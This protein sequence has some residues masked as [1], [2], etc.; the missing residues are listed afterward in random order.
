[1]SDARMAHRQENVHS[2]ADFLYH[3]QRLTHSA[4]PA[5]WL[6]LNIGEAMAVSLVLLFIAVFQDT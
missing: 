6:R 2:E 4:V 3:D 1:M 5:Q